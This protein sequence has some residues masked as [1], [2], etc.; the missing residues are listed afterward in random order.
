MTDREEPETQRARSDDAEQSTAH[1]EGTA[2]RDASQHVVGEAGSNFGE[3]DPG[4][5]AGFGTAAS[6]ADV[7][8][9]TGSG[10]D[11]DTA[12]SSANR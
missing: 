5:D 10:N 3:V 2:G 12:V 9:D 6:G 11:P 4:V 1:G 7:T 8:G